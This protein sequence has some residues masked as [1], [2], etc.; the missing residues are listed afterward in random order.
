MVDTT[1]V[2]IFARI[3]DNDHCIQVISK[4]KRFNC[5]WTN[6]HEQ[7][8]FQIEKTFYECERNFLIKHPF[9]S[10]FTEIQ[11]IKLKMV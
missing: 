10:C 9:L 1:P 5:F 8:L 2:I 3:K 6:G 11:L 4:S 7:A